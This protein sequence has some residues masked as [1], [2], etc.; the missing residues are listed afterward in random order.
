M[1]F[2]GLSAF[3]VNWSATLKEIYLTK[4]TKDHYLDLTYKN[5][6]NIATI[7]FPLNFCIGFAYYYSKSQ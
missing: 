7:K 2:Y 6:K 4:G 5:K 3:F 1:K